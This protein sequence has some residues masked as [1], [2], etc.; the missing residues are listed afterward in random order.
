MRK[1]MTERQA[2]RAC[3]S[4]VREAVDGFILKEFPK[5]PVQKIEVTPGQT[6]AFDAKA[7]TVYAFMSAFETSTRFKKR[8]RA[9]GAKVAKEFRI[10]YKSAVMWF[11]LY[12]PG[13][14]KALSARS[15]KGGK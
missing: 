2:K 11:K 8:I 3:V 9:A 12:R 14:Y 10:A 6:I 4:L 13:I 1:M 15:N 7:A 5:Q